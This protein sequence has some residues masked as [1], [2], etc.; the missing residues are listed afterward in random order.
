MLS[1]KQCMARWS[2]AGSGASASMPNAP[3]I[4]QQVEKSVRTTG[5]PKIHVNSKIR[6]N[7]RVALIDEFPLRRG[8]VLNM[9]RLHL[10][11]GTSAFSSADELFS[12]LP[13]GPDSS[14]CTILSVGGRS[15]TQA[16]V[17]DTLHRVGR[18][19]GA[20]GRCALIVLSDRE[21]V[22]EVLASFRAGARG[23]IPTSLDPRLVIAAIRLVVAG[24]AFIPATTVVRLDRDVPSELDLARRT[25]Q[26]AIES[27]RHWPARQL[28]VLHLLGE[29]KTNKNIATTLGMEESTVKVHV[30]HIMRKL[31]AKNR[32]QVALYVRRLGPVADAAGASPEKSPREISDGVRVAI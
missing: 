32:T 9:L 22:E 15:V 3:A 21:E 23:F 25:D 16:P 30:R 4:A 12:Q 8:S 18:L 19:G 6:V 20:P 14:R 28:A 5:E 29:G 17:A 1:D 27:P 26:L 10:C 31:G 2:S 24:G 7:I 11:K 13:V